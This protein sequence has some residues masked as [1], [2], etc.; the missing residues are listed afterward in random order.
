MAAEQL[1]TDEQVNGVHV[2]FGAAVLLIVAIVIEGNATGRW[3]EF[4]SMAR[5]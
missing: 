2:R 4:L 1:V 3:D 5:A